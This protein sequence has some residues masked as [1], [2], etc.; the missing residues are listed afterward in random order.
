MPPL[1]LR[2]L[3]AAILLGLAGY[4]LLRR[5]GPNPWIGVRLPWT[6]ADREIWDKSWLLAVLILVG[7]GLG[8]LFSW[9]F[10]VVSLL[11]MIALGILYPLFLYHRKYGTWRYWQDTGWLEYR[12]AAKCS[13]CGHIQKLEEAGELV[14][15]HC[16]ACG[17]SLG[18]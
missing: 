3:L 16:G 11:A 8:A 14:G 18:R 13:Q 1:A 10:F 9:T 5:H 4:M 12:P 6:F 15:A 2:Y 7:M 17:A